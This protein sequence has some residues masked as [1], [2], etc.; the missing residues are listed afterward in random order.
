MVVGPYDIVAIAMVLGAAIAFVLGGAALARTEDLLA[1]Y[2]MLVGFV[3][4]RAAVQLAKSG[5]GR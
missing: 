5:S 2:W 4:L 3:S 1:G